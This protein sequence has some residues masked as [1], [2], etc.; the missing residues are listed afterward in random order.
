MA[1]DAMGNDLEEQRVFLVKRGIIGAGWVC[2]PKEFNQKQVQEAIWAEHIDYLPGKP[3]IAMKRVNKDS[4]LMSS[5]NCSEDC[6]RQH[7]YVIG[8]LAGVMLCGWANM[9]EE[10]DEEF[11]LLND[12]G[13]AYLSPDQAG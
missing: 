13:T 4:E 3:Y 5:G 8:G 7:W 12:N 6:N 9:S 11:K 10:Q 1:K 2:A